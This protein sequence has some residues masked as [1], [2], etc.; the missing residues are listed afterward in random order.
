MSYPHRPGT[1]AGLPA[2]SGT[3]CR[4]WT[5]RRT[6]T[7][8]PI[9]RVPM[10]RYEIMALTHN[11]E[12]IDEVR[13]APA[14]PIF[15]AAFCA[16]ARGTILHTDEGHVAVEDL[17][18]GMQVAT[19]DHGLQTLMWR[20][21]THI[22]ANPDAPDKGHALYRIPM[23]S[24]GPQRPMPDL[25][26]GPYA[27]I[28]HRNPALTSLIGRDDALAPVSAFA[29]GH[30]VI[31]V[32]PASSVRVFHLG[33]SRHQVVEANGL[34]IETMHP[35][36]EVANLLSLEE[37]RSYL[38]LFPHVSGISMFGPLRIPRLSQEACEAVLAA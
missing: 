24:F 29:D 38:S 7:P 3:E 26:L 1:G 33:F 25:L 31:R 10:R 2:V 14:I 30:S 13:A 35:G 34:A 32:T 22:A 18:P 28:L 11:G 17:V 8:R 37:L 15:E 6:A 5:A 23:D 19:R 12:L 36:P 21:A 16:M 4:R 20:G 9:T 27:R